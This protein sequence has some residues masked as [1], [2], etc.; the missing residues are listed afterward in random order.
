MATTTTMAALL[1]R[2]GSGQEDMLLSVFSCIALIYL[3][4]GRIRQRLA[5]SVQRITWEAR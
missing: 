3:I 2:L 1:C 4:E 5:R